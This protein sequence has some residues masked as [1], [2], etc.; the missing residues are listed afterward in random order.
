MTRE[1]N[2]YYSI[3]VGILDKELPPQAAADGRP[4]ADADKMDCQTVRGCRGTSKSAR[5]HCGISTGGALQTEK[6]KLETTT[7]STRQVKG[8]EM[9]GGGGVRRNVAN[10]GSCSITEM[11]SALQ[12]ELSA[13]KLLQ[14]GTLGLSLSQ[15]VSE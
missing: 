9:E 7:G 13:T 2:I 3:V 6:H 14:N 1:E 15:Q 5:R 12:K 4:E 10:V 8:Q 11:K